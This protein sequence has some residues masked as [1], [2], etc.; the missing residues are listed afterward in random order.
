MKN[1]A[2]NPLTE[3]V[4]ERGKKQLKRV[5]LTIDVLYAIMIF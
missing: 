3:V 5:E 2:Q 1:P 4:L